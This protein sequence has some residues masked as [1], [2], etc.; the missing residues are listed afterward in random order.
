MIKRYPFP[1]STLWKIL[2]VGFVFS[3]LYLVRESQVSC[4]LL[5]F[6]KAQ[7][8]TFGI[9]ALAATAFLVVQRQQLREILLNPRLPIALTLCL[10]ILIPMA[11]KQDWQ[12]M[13]FN[14]VF[15]I[16]LAVLLTYFVSCRQ[17]AL[18]YVGI[19]T[20]LAVFSLVTSYGLRFLADRGI[21]VPPLFSNDY[22]A[23]FYNYILSFVSVTFAKE[24]NFGIFREPGVYQFF[25][26][27]ALY[28]NNYYTDWKKEAH[29]WIVNGILVITMLSTFATGGV[30]ATGLFV[31][32]VYFDKKVYKSKIGRV[33]TVCVLGLTAAAGA[34][35]LIFKPRVYDILY[36]MVLKLFTV[37]ASLSDRLDSIRFN[38]EVIQ[39]T[40]LVG[41]D[42][43]YILHTVTHNT[44]SST[45]LFGILGVVSGWLNLIGWFCFVRRGCRKLW[46]TLL[47]F[48]G[49]L[50]T[51]NTQNFITDPFFWLFPIMVMTE[52]IL[53]WLARI[54]QKRDKS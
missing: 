54:G 11:A 37:N 51:F 4:Y 34:C 2:F 46:V 36:L 9:T 33:L 29:M 6:Y 20:V 8:L 12:M 23:E 45:I 5:G 27:L 19:V 15:C 18:V 40:P 28:L 26:F 30:A 43:S 39:W 31:W 41:R 22:E 25:L 38:L 42:V 44:S 35:I 32:A 48:L 7:F 50:V 52:D 24:R 1:Q 49:L 14:I 13:Y 21:L 47:C 16:L 53:L 10:T 17:V 3:L